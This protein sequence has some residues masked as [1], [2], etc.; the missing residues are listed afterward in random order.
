MLRF[1]PLAALL[2][3][4]TMLGFTASADGAWPGQ[5]EATK[6]V[7]ANPQLL[8]TTA[9]LAEH[10]RTAGVVVVDV[11]GAKDFEAGHVPGA[12]SIPTSVTYDPESRRNIGPPELIAALLGAQGI[13]ASNHVVI[14]DAGKSTA[15]ARVF[16]TLEVYGHKQVSVV[17]GGFAKWRAEKR[18]MTGA[19]TAVTPVEY[20]IGSQPG[21]RSTLDQVLEDVEDPGAVMLDARSSREFEA[22]R[23]PAAVHIEWARNY[24][25]D[26]VP[27]F[28]SPGE[29]LELYADQGVTPDKR[30]HAY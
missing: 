18:E 8:V 24:T 3:S 26:E 9:W 22:G 15:A 1:Q 13:A 20:V 19:P 10:G 17:D 29:L 11:R 6:A 12:V 2:L 5:D 21:R 28:K 23:I 16:W 30:V 27:V 25:A 14:Y 4:T 7:F